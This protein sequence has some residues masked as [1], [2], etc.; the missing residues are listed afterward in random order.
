MLYAIVI[1]SMCLAG[2]GQRK[3]G[4]KRNRFVYERGSK[5]GGADVAGEARSSG[6]EPIYA[7]C[8]YAGYVV[9][10]GTH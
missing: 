6:C 3:A 1:C 2:G 10:W 7:K 9:G 8:D 4:P 5:T